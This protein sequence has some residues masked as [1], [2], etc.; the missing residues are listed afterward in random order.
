[1]NVLQDMSDL[2]SLYTQNDIPDAQNKY[3]YLIR[4]INTFLTPFD[5]PIAKNT[6]I[7]RPL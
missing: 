7:G 3:D 4:N 5:E 2:I 6:N 1:M